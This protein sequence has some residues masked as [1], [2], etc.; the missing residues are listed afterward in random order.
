MKA[1]WCNIPVA[2]PWKGSDHFTKLLVWLSKHID[3]RDWDWDVP[4]DKDEFHRVY[5]FAH[6]VDAILFALK[7]T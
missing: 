4:Y 6:K 1:D 7:W 3:E 5:Y 2:M